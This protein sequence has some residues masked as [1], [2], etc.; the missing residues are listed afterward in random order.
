M[1]VHKKR[2]RKN[3]I[4]RK[5]KKTQ[6]IQNERNSKEQADRYTQVNGTKT[7]RKVQHDTKNKTQKSDMYMSTESAYFQT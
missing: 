7:L 3:F 1:K 2:D 4:R 5:N 6:K